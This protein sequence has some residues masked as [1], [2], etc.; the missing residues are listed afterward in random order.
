MSYPT[1]ADCVTGL[2]PHDPSV[3]LARREAA[4]LWQGDSRFV[5]Y[6]N[7]YIGGCAL[8][9]RARTLPTTLQSDF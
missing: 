6:V 9:A 8:C 1:K 3:T 7:E 2:N 4:T 5:G